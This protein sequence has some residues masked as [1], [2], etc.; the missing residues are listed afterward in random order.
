MSDGRIESKDFSARRF[1]EIVHFLERRRTGTVTNAIRAMTKRPETLESHSSIAAIYTRRRR[2]QPTVKMLS[3][4]ILCSCKQFLF[5]VPKPTGKRASE[6]RDSS[7]GSGANLIKLMTRTTKAPSEIRLIIN[8][9]RQQKS[10]SD[11]GCSAFVSASDFR[12]TVPA[13]SERNGFRSEAN[14]IFL[15]HYENNRTSITVDENL[16]LFLLS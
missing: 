8:R 11:E 12:S 5:M 2:S 13:R 3:L 1:L 7:S 9:F 10:L 16:L 6:A 14:G 15:H 4:Y